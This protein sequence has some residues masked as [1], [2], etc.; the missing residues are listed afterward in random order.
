MLDIYREL[1]GDRQD[2]PMSKVAIN[3]RFLRAIWILFYVWGSSGGDGDREA[4]ESV[5]PIR[6]QHGGCSK[7]L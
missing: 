5:V 4:G 2:L 6:T 7:G 1:Q 3:T